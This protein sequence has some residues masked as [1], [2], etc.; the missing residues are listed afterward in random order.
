MGANATV[1]YAKP[2]PANPTAP[3]QVV[4]VSD[5]GLGAAHG[6]GTGDINGDGRKDI[7]NN[8][9]W[10]E[11]PPAG[12]T[13]GHW[14]FHAAPFG[15]GGA[16]MGVYDVNGDG[17]PDIVTGIMAHGWG[18][19]WVEHQRTAQ[20][21]ITF[22]R[23]D[24]MGDF[25]TAAKNAGGVTFSESHGMAFGDGGGGGGPGGGGGGRRGARRDR[26]L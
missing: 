14:K 23:H 26:R 21:E 1:A 13:N 16:E 4:T 19:A 25:S 15:N 17:L 5:P 8:L 18:L 12:D 24:I 7:V 3:W 6:M 10:R 2:D 20:G 22:V 11:G 9:G